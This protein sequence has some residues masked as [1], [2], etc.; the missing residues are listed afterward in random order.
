V[1]I[2][3]EQAPLSCCVG[4]QDE[5]LGGQMIPNP[6]VNPG[7]IAD[8]FLGA[9]LASPIAIGVEETY[10]YFWRVVFPRY[11]SLLNF[12]WMHRGFS[13]AEYINITFPEL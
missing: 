5:G 2:P 13:T 6:V 4:A 11:W 8:A 7:C 3:R 10:G 12:Q 9:T 1:R